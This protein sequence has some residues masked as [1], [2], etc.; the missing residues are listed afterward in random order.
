MTFKDHFSDNSA[1]YQ[2]YRP[3]YPD[4]LFTYLASIAPSHD[5]AWDCATGSGQSALVLSEHFKQV[6]A[7]DASANQLQH[8][9]QK[10][11]VTYRVEP[12]E[13]TSFADASVDLITV[14]QAVHW[15]DLAR[16]TDEVL[17]VLK[18]EGIL[19]I[20]TYGVLTIS[21]QIDKLVND[22]YGPTLNQYW[23]PERA[24]IDRG[25][26]DIDFPLQ[27]ITTPDFAMQVE[28]NLSQL[29]GYLCTWSAV[30]RY[31][32][33]IG[34]NPVETLYDDLAAA[35]GDVS[36]KRVTHWPFTLRA[37]RHYSD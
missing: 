12:A 19:A 27:E 3:R 8:A 33:A 9:P 24:M 2:A 31:T 15:F 4:E 1:D 5:T 6:I 10:D 18:H 14:A 13:R 32:T 28:W 29:V 16:F 35:W 20:W 30:K 36:R 21:P 17:R 34:T 37:W 25:Y 7:T 22:L 11:G 26:R 23:P